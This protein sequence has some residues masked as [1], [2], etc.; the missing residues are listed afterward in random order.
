MAEPL[1][2]PN[3]K[4]A[5]RQ[6]SEI[7][8]SMS[9]DADVRDAREAVMV[10]HGRFKQ[11]ETM[12]ERVEAPYRQKLDELKPYIETQ[13]L[14]VEQSFEAHGFKVKYISGYER[15]TLKSNELD[16]IR[17]GHPELYRQLKPFLSTTGRK[18]ST[19]L[20]E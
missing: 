17:A 19:K 6:Y 15:E 1:I 9:A 7:Y 4:E 20:A 2:P 14:E 5:L 18:P 3:L 11:A 8:H 12:L 16:A 10:A 13:A